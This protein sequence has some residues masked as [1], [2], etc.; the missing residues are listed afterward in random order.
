M[1][2]CELCLNLE[3]VALD[4]GEQAVEFEALDEFLVVKGGHVCFSK[5]LYLL[6]YAYLLFFSTLCD[7]MGFEEIADFEIAIFARIALE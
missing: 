5:N 7:Q 6:V 3:T 1:V 2:D 4:E